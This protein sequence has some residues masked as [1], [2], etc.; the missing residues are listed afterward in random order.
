MSLTQ[1]V[2]HHSQSWQETAHVQCSIKKPNSKYPN[3]YMSFDLIL[4]KPVLKG[5][6]LSAETN[7]HAER[8]GWVC[9]C[10]SGAAST[11]SNIKCSGSVTCTSCFPQHDPSNPCTVHLARI[12]K[13]SG[14]YHPGHHHLPLETCSWVAATA[15]PALAVG[16][17]RTWVQ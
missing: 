3:R 6:M 5:K 13:G 14:R 15:M 4:R 2:K 8:R 7:Q 1:N 9:C 16:H 12:P 17:S 11:H 10:V